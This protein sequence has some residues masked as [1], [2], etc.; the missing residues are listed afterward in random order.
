[1]AIIAP[2]IVY[3]DNIP[4]NHPS[5]IQIYPD[6]RNK[7]FYCQLTDKNLKV[8]IYQKKWILQT[9]D[10][11]K[12]VESFLENI[13]FSLAQKFPFI[14]CETTL[15]DG[16]LFKKEAK[17]YPEFLTWHNLSS[18]IKHYTI[19]NLSDFSL[20]NYFFQ[21]KENTTFF[22]NSLS[23]TEY[24]NNFCSL[25]DPETGQIEKKNNEYKVLKK[26]L[27]EEDF[28][29]FHLA[30]GIKSGNLVLSK[31]N[32]KF[33][34]M[35]SELNFSKQKIPPK[36]KLNVNDN[37]YD[38]NCLSNNYL[39]YPNPSAVTWYLNGNK[40]IDQKA[41]VLEKK[42]ISYGSNYRCENNN[43]RSEKLDINKD[44]LKLIGNNQI[45]IKNINEYYSQNYF[46]SLDLTSNKISWECEA[47][48]AVLCSIMPINKQGSVKLTVKFNDKYI[49][50]EIEN[51][52][53]LKLKIEDDIIEKKVIVYKENEKIENIQNFSHKL[54]LEEIDGENAYYCKLPKEFISRANY[55]VF[56]FL[57]ETEVVKYRGSFIFNDKFKNGYLSC[58]V[59]GRDIN[60]GY[61]AAAVKKHSNLNKKNPSWLK[62][63]YLF[64]V[65]KAN[66]I[67]LFQENNYRINYELFCFL[68][69]YN[70]QKITDNICTK[71]K[72][73][74]YY[75]EITSNNYKN[76]MN[77][78]QKNEFVDPYN[79]PNLPIFMRKYGNNEMT[80]LKTSL[81]V[82][83]PNYRP[84]IHAA[85]LV[86]TGNLQKCF[87]IA[88]DPQN[89]YLTT[90]FVLDKNKTTK[91]LSF[92]NKNYFFDKNDNIRKKYFFS[93][94][95]VLYEYAF[96]FSEPENYCNIYVSNG[97]EIIY[98]KGEKISPENYENS[99]KRVELLKTSDDL[100]LTQVLKNISE[101]S[102]FTISSPDVLNNLEK[103][104]VNFSS[105]DSNQ[106][107]VQIKY[108]FYQDVS[109][110][111]VSYLPDIF[112]D[113]GKMKKSLIFS[114]DQGFIQ[115]KEQ[116]RKDL[117]ISTRI[118]Q[119]KKNKKKFYCEYNFPSKENI[120]QVKYTIFLNLKQLYSK[121][122]DRPGTFFE[123]PD[124][125][126]GD[127]VIC[128]TEA[129]NIFERSLFNGLD[130]TD[131]QSL[132]YATDKSN[133][134]LI[135]VCPEKL[136]YYKS[137]K[138]IKKIISDYL[139][140]NYSDYSSFEYVSI[141]VWSIS[142]KNKYSIAFNFNQELQEKK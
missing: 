63:S 56:W 86:N 24:E 66:K 71:D 109:V 94:G 80:D 49:E 43:G 100:K 123:L 44:L 42:Y 62:E 50:N 115:E 32:V 41:S 122:T 136:N 75:L 39:Y 85:G 5:Y 34:L 82:I 103:I 79:I 35:K 96:N 60:Q 3:F 25:L 91:I 27:G 81:R 114:N 120:N 70:Y 26:L 45:G 90:R 17:T 95:Y 104:K 69:D 23:F 7:K 52:V 142:G 1:M 6:Y 97:T 89:L 137:S 77:F 101:K 30:V 127:T 73:G 19:S 106:N 68:Y 21:Q 116:F 98:A 102:E 84:I 22:C 130:Y 113:I 83:L 128:Q 64:D 9:Q 55:Q 105:V 10:K 11:Q 59:F 133:A 118:F 134:T 92:F 33:V 76:L 138:E 47:S 87:V 57:N 40:I 117:F 139:V 31:N 78:F 110:L 8:K 135:F 108:L 119:D 121:I 67:L 132:C 140:E 12:K 141:N 38:L 4:A 54:N 15:F 74:R 20:S 107:T 125:Q 13:D 131:K 29:I 48:P 53:N 126:D 124:Y 46:T 112:F 51:F 14:T 65:L 111:N 18:E 93:N 88:R 61:L 129:D 16:V 72:L 36:L 99:L 37:I 28:R 2:D 58:V